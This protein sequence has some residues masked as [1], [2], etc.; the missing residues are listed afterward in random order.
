M[1][2][3]RTFVTRVAGLLAVGTVGPRLLAE[4]SASPAGATP[5]TIYKSKSCGCCANW[6]GY[7][8][9]AGFETTIRD[10][11]DMDAIKDQLGVPEQ[12]RSCHTAVVDRYLVEG[13]VPVPDI[14]RL[15]S[16]KPKLLGLAVPGMPPGTP[17]MAAPGAPIAGFDVIGFTS[18]GSTRTIARY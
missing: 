2:D 7:V 12:V 4:L 15:L 1:I 3:R 18:D 9:E 10:E 5:I 16:E 11:D 6:V 17:G 13:H 14:R 8:R